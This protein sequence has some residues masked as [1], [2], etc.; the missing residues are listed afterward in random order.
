[1]NGKWGKVRRRVSWIVLGDGS[2]GWYYWKG[3]LDC[4]SGF[5]RMVLGDG[6][7]RWYC[8]INKLG[9]WEG[10]MVWVSWMMLWEGSVGWYYGLVSGIVVL[11]SA[12]WG[13]GKCLNK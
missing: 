5:S 7:I 1:M 13:F 4:A 3:Q 11:E 10:V 8:V 12:G 9:Q 6:S 2:F